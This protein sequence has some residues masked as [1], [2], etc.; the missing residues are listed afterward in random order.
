LL[1]FPHTGKVKKGWERKGVFPRSQVIIHRDI[2]LVV[3]NWTDSPCSSS[4][5]ENH[6]PDKTGGGIVTIRNDGKIKKASTV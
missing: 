3:L 6:W 5:K 2:W 4:K 1:I